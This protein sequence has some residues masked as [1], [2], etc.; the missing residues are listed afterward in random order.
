MELMV[1][2]PRW[3]ILLVI[4]GLL[5]LAIYLPRLRSMGRLPE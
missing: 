5:V 3:I 2:D 1:D 4:F